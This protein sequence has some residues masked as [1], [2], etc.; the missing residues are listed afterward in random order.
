MVM[1]TDEMML[2]LFITQ[3]VGYWR[4]SLSLSAQS[5]GTRGEGLLVV[6]NRNYSYPS[7]RTSC[8]QIA[9]RYQF[10]ITVCV[11]Y[12]WFGGFRFMPDLKLMSQIL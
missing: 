9:L 5:C 2:S 6:L 1:M 8:D 12:I 11:I 7:P 4:Q 3:E 10:V